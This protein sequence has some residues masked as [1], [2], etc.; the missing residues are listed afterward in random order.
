[1][2]NNVNDVQETKPVEEVE[3]Q[4]ID[5]LKWWQYPLG[6]LVLIVFL[7][8]I[9]G[10]NFAIASWLWGANVCWDFLMNNWGK[11]LVL[12]LVNFIL[13]KP[14][15]SNISGCFGLI[16]SVFWGI[17]VTYVTSSL[18]WS[19]DQVNGFICSNWKVISVFYLLMF[20][21]CLAVE[22]NTLF[23]DKK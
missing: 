4:E 17:P 2:E 23:H 18:L 15:Q 10:G 11:L 22:I 20:L 3:D 13:V 14:L 16:V 8:V 7:G 19:M 9:F 5:K 1:M 6:C 12:Y 21:F